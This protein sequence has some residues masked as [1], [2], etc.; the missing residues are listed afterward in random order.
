MENRQ[1]AV[2]DLEMNRSFWKGR[3]VFVTGHTGFKGSWL[4]LWLNDLGAEVSGY[5]LSPPTNPSLFR[6][7]R[8][9]DGLDDSTLGDVRDAEGVRVSL[10]KA[11]AEVVFH[12]AAQPLVR[13]SYADPVGTYAVNVMGTVN[14]L[15]AVRRCDSVR[16]VVNVTTDKVYENKEWI[17]GYRECDR[18]GG[19]DPYSSSKACSELVTSAYRNSFFPLTDYA[20]HKVAIASARS[21]NVIGGGDWAAGRLIPDCVRAFTKGENVEI[22]YPRSTRPWQHVLE[23]IAGYIMLAERLYTDG[24]AVSGAW[25]FAPERENAKPVEWIVDT[26]TRLWGKGASFSVRQGE[27]PHEAGFLFLDNSKAH[28]FLKWKPRLSISDALRL[29]VEWFKAF[30]E[31]AETRELCREQIHG[32]ENSP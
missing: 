32:Y 9:E 2:E 8:L 27:Q 13:E 28:N 29:T 22:R 31:G 11:K 5:A 12:L 1:G 6:T 15:E 7:S 16:V 19:Y 17:W 25:N 18:L 10:Q 26:M 20:K 21:G 14:L 4:S 3:R 30:Q 24:P 23:P